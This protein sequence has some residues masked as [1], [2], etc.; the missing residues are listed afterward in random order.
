M[1]TVYVIQRQL[2]RDQETGD[3]VDR[4]DLGPAE[5]YGRIV[6][7]LEPN[8]SA[9]RSKEVIRDLRHALSR[10]TGNDYLLLIGNP[11]IIGW[12][13]AIAAEFSGGCVKMLQWNSQQQ[14]YMVVE[15]DI[16]D[17]K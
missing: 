12:S 2:R 14:A 16:K 7:L 15:G 13:T 5:Q 1:N 10:F 11:C 6:F 8:A 9:F 4:F 17:N 3:I